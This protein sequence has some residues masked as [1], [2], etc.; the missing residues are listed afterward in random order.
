MPDRPWRLR[1][2]TNCGQTE[3]AVVDNATNEEI[4]VTFKYLGYWWVNNAGAM[5]NRRGA[6]EQA[7]ADVWESRDV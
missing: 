3:W 2:H 6:R 5:S 1:R 7:A 4:G